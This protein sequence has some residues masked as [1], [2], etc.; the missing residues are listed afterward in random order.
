VNAMPSQNTPSQNM[1][2]TGVVQVGPEENWQ[3]YAWQ[4][5]NNDHQITQQMTSQ[6]TG[7]FAYA[8]DDSG[9]TVTITFQGDG[10]VAPGQLPHTSPDARAMGVMAYQVD[11]EPLLTPGTEPDASDTSDGNY[12]QAVEAIGELSKDLNSAITLSDTSP[13][14]IDQTHQQTTT[15]SVQDGHTATSTDQHQ[16]TAT[17]S[18]QDGTST[19]ASASADWS[20]FGPQVEVSGSYSQNDS[21]DSGTSDTDGTESG[22]SD[23]GGTDS[24][25]QDA[26]TITDWGVINNANPATRVASWI[27]H[28]QVPYD[29]NSYVGGD[30]NW[31]Q[32][33]AFDADGSVKEFAPLSTSTMP[34]K[35]AASWEVKRSL[36]DALPGKTLYFQLKDTINAFGAFSSKFNSAGHI[37]AYGCTGGT[38]WSQAIDLSELLGY[39][40]EDPAQYEQAGYAQEDPAQYEQADAQE[41]PAQ[42][43]QAGYA[44]EDPAQY[45]QAGYAQEDP[46]QYQQN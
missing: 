21:T 25:A 23:T 41:D 42:Y 44:Q 16:H 12:G 33:V 30:P 43:Q 22:T 5:Q 24:G 40:Q 4:I 10:T 45:Q 31:W 15:Y 34:V 6:W 13:Q 7:Q 11:I 32:T 28:Q 2:K 35:V 18:E 9:E 39:G 8:L 37:D 14:T 26:L 27:F 36:I 20:L 1:T 46:A 38:T 3:P 29:W 19:G 17:A